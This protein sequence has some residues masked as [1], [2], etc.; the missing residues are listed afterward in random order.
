MI[1]LTQGKVWENGVD[2]HWENDDKT[3]YTYDSYGNIITFASIDQSM[4]IKNHL[5]YSQMM[6][7]PR[8]TS[9][10]TISPM[11]ITSF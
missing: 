5:S 2:T 11:Y 4:L 6:S 3:E 7:V 8:G 1:L 10:M 9:L